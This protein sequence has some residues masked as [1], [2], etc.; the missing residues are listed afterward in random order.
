MYIYYFEGVATQKRDIENGMFEVN[1]ETRNDHRK[2]VTSVHAWCHGANKQMG[3]DL[4]LL[5]SQLDSAPSIDDQTVIIKGT[6]NFVEKVQVGD[7]RSQVKS[8]RQLKCVNTDHY[9]DYIMTFRKI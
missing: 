5:K 8:T 3:R 7:L 4:G 1:F 2:L 6:L 9:Y